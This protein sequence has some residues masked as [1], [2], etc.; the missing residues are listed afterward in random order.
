[1]QRWQSAPLCLGLSFD[2]QSLTLLEGPGWCWPPEPGLRWAQAA[3][4]ASDNPV[5][6]PSPVPNPLMDPV[7]LG[8]SVR[9]AW[10][11]SGMRCRRLAMGVPADQV[12][13][14]VLQIDADLPAHEVRT[15][16]QW[17]ASQA[18]A[19][20]WQE[21][22]F[23]YQLD[24]AARPPGPRSEASQTVHWL[25]CPLAWVQW[26]QQM[27]RAAQLRLQ[28]LGVEPL[29]LQG[30]ADTFM[31]MSAPL[32]WQRASEMARQGAGT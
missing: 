5:P 16:V 8:T 13:Q 3:W 11:G 19:M 31:Q 14:Q 29:G 12:V 25:A 24:P 22:A 4:S 27:S 10:Q 26:A 1:M 17:Q 7:A 9:T 20:E 28:F 6:S 23:D 2:A 18:L 21:V 30:S 15:Q 32:Q